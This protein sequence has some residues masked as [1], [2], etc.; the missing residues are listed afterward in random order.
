MELPH[1]SRKRFI[2]RHTEISKHIFKRLMRDFIYLHSPLF[3]FGPH[4]TNLIILTL[5]PL[6]CYEPNCCQDLFCLFYTESV[7]RLRG[8]TFQEAQVLCVIGYGSH[9]QAPGGDLNSLRR[10][11]HLK[12]FQGTGLV[13]SV[14]YP[15]LDLRVESEPHDGS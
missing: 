1:T 6:S 12:C 14:E 11:I 7:F 10:W 4:M 2:H 8:P 3:Y 13:Q 9:R 5:V 15:I